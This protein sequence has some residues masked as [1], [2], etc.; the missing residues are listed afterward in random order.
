MLYSRVKTNGVMEAIFPIKDDSGDR[1]MELFVYD[2]GG[3][4]IERK[5]WIHAFEKVDI[6]IFTVDIACYDQLLYEDESVNRMSEALTLFNSVVNSRWFVKS[7]MILCFTKGAKLAAKI[8]HSPVEN[9]FPDF[10]PTEP[11]SLQDTTAYFITRF[12]NLDERRGR[13]TE[14]PLTTLVLQDTLNPDEWQVIKQ[15]A[16]RLCDNGE[17]F[18]QAQWTRTGHKRPRLRDRFSGLSSV[19]EE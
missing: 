3:V 1:T 11:P 6:V 5:Y 12:K 14:R 13:L 2:V 8:K 4:R 18:C 19:E 10:V 7:E 9:Y 17:L 16:W 15:I